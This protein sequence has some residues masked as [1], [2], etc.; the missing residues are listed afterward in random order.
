M[1]ASFRLQ[2]CRRCSDLSRQAHRAAS[3]R[4]AAQRSRA[5]PDVPPRPRRRRVGHG[6]SHTRS[7]YLRARPRVRDAMQAAQF[8]ALLAVTQTGIVTTERAVRRHRSA[9]LAVAGKPRMLA[10]DGGRC[11][12]AGRHGRPVAFV[13]VARRRRNFSCRRRV[14]R[15]GHACAGE[16][17]RSDR[18]GGQNFNCLFSPRFNPNAATSAG[19]L[20]FREVTRSKLKIRHWNARRYRFRSV[21]ITLLAWNFA[22]DCFV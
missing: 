22:N 10:G 6:A 7:E 21:L 12:G 5:A 16:Q 3:R 15:V 20:A 17:G 2:P 13:D 1:S 4:S 18:D 11:L 14:L 8:V 9:E 19:S